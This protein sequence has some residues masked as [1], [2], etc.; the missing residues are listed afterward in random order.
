[1]KFS[2]AWVQSVLIGVVLLVLDVGCDRSPVREAS[3][4][5]KAPAPSA[6]GWF[7]DVTA[8]SGVR[9]IHVAGTNYHMP[10][11]VGSGVAVLDFDRDGRWDLYFVQNGG[12]AAKAGAARNQL[13]HQRA[14]GSFENA[15]AQSGADVVGAGMGVAAG[16]LNNDGWTDLVVT[17]NGAVRVLLNRNGRFEEVGKASGVENPRWCVPASFVDFDR[18]GWLDIIVGNYLDYDRTQVCLDSQGRRDFCAPSAFAGTSLRLWRNVTGTPGGTPRFE[19]VTGR[20]GL[21]RSTGAAMGLVC[22]DFTDDGWPDIFVADDG[23]PN[24]LLVNQR[25]GTFTDEAMVRGV[26]FNAMGHTAAN[27]GLAWGDF[28]NDGRMDLF[29]THLAEEFHSLFQQDR[30]GFFSD[31][32]ASAGFQ[33][34]SWRGTGFGVVAADFDLDGDLDVAWVNGLV[35]RAS[36][37]QTPTDPGLDPWW[38]RYAQR[39]QLFENLGSG[40][41]RDVSASNGGLTGLAMVGRGLA[42]ADLNSDGAPDLIAAPIGGP[43]HVYRNRMS[44]KGRWITLRLLEPN[45]GGRDAI[46]AEVVVSAGG[47]RWTGLLQPSTSY[48]SSHAP[49][50]SFGL[51]TV[52]R[53]DSIEVLWVGGVK[54]KFSGGGVDRVLEL[55]RG[56]GR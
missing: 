19:D 28:N 13:F 42:M 34:Q 52:D 8:A 47:R 53:I 22:A 3:A 54:E 38:A 45:F 2:T 14:D 23:R 48:A 7:E 18:D 41:L 12:S 55:K 1:M 32:I 46:G 50:V 56:S 27:M 11:Q 15:S 24:R 17:E 20:S 29:V 25:D 31:Q 26:A 37:G 10:D 6:Q 49:A 43:A 30:S 51:G 39:A 36:P 33:Q 5:A 4:S 9:F 21:S 44:G 16:D 35:R 40:R